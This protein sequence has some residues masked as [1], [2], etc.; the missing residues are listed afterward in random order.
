MSL[1]DCIHG[2]SLCK[3]E[4]VGLL[5]FKEHLNEID[6]QE[7]LQCWQ[8]DQQLEYSPEKI[9]DKSSKQKDENRE[10]SNW[11]A[12]DFRGL[13]YFS[14]AHYNRNLRGSWQS[15]RSPPGQPRNF[16][17]HPQYHHR[18]VFSR[19]RIRSDENPEQHAGTHPPW[20]GGGGNIIPQEFRGGPPFNGGMINNYY[21]NQGNNQ[22]LWRR[23][24]M[25]GQHGGKANNA[26]DSFPVCGGRPS[27]DAEAGASFRREPQNPFQ[28][29]RRNSWHDSNV[30]EVKHTKGETEETAVKLNMQPAS[31][32]NTKSE[33]TAPSTQAKIECMSKEESCIDNKSKT[34]DYRRT[35]NELINSKHEQKEIASG[36]QAK[37]QNDSKEG[38]YIEKMAKSSDSGR[39]S[40]EL[41]TSKREQGENTP[42]TKTQAENGSKEEGYLVYGTQESSD[43]TLSSESATGKNARK[44]KPRKLA[45]PAEEEKKEGSGDMSS[46]GDLT[47]SKDTSLQS[48]TQDRISSH[49]GYKNGG[50]GKDM[51]RSTKL[52][53]KTFNNEKG[54]ATTGLKEDSSTVVSGDF[55]FAEKRESLSN[56]KSNHQT[57]G[58]KEPLLCSEEQLA[59]KRKGFQ[60]CHTFLTDQESLVSVG[61]SVTC[62]EKRNEP[63][64]SSKRTVNSSQTTSK[65]Q[66]LARISISSLKTKWVSNSKQQAESSGK[67]SPLPT[68]GS[69]GTKNKAKFPHVGKNTGAKGKTFERTV[70]GE[71]KPNQNGHSC[72]PTTSSNVGELPW[73][74]KEGKLKSLLGMDNQPKDSEVFKL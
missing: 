33:E 72:H 1:S 15:D 44:G 30:S 45:R 22:C 43:R 62:L 40:N 20:I 34:S 10:M 8:K 7:K 19:E 58:N 42:I 32:S 41:V 46:A 48:V 49:V 27:Y 66:S 11:A 4:F 26:H 14:D 37:G 53:D 6:H 2:C 29:S 51:E 64:N 13:N 25:D 23:N 59:E 71:N 63:F 61:N 12:D 50:T 5:K 57:K 73:R 55:S 65:E 67:T 18:E 17:P 69:F 56:Q 38:S 60:G 70:I 35:K 52:L 16:F 3:Q 24:S 54:V 31:T 74:K 39:T 28:P 36:T 9:E 68:C 21:L 47:Q